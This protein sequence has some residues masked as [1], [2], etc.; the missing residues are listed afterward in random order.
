[1]KFIYL[2]LQ[3]IYSKFQLLNEKYFIENELPETRN[4]KMHKYICRNVPALK[5]YVLT[6]MRAFWL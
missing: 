5:R 4:S 3:Y 2:I 1:M 6:Y